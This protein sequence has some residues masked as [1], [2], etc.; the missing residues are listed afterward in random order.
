MIGLTARRCARLVI[1]L[2]LV[3][4]PILAETLNTPECG[5]ALN[6]ASR[7]VRGVRERQMHF[8]RYD[9]AENCRLLRENLDDLVAARGPLDRCP[10]GEEHTKDLGQI[11]AAIE[12]IRAQLV[13]N[14]RR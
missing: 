2:A 4:R 10:T 5:S 11:D 12:Q 8:S 3:A 13:G 9:P 7:L 14:C 6:D 1:A